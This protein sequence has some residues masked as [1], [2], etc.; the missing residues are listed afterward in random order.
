MRRKGF[1]L[2]ELL[3][4]IAIIAIL[5][6]LLLPAVQK[7]REAA[8]RMSCT[9]NLKQIALA[10]HNFHDTNGKFPYG[11]LRHD[12]G[13]HFPPD[14]PTLLYP[15]SPSVNPNRRYALMHQILPFIEQDSLWRRWDHLTF[16]NNRKDENGVMFGPGW[17][18][19]RQI[20]KTLVCPSNPVSGRP[21]NQPVDPAEAGRY[22]LVSY[23]G[24]AG[25]RSYPGFNASR[26]CLFNYKDGVFER[27]VAHS[28]ADVLDGTSNTLLFGERHYYDP[29]FDSDPSVDDRIA[30]WG[31]CWYGAE[32]DAF[33]ST[34]VPINYRLPANT[35]ITQLMFDD[36]INAFGSGHSGGANFA[37]ADG[38]VRFV[39]D[40]ISPVTFKSLGTRALGEVIGN[41]F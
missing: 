19:M 2:I 9:N 4:V 35:T 22:F 36:R 39:K 21:L 11:M 15:N 1:T 12:G 25:T 37:L 31:W 17:V 18:F 38:S 5:I 27:N 40:S 16:D 33:L 32:G 13:G 20:V 10:A 6:G 28:I 7:V 14:N 24:C 30:D 26:P 34:S 29:V 41:D 23:Y 8:N 3:V